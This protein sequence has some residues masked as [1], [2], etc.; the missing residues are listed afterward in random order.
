MIAVRSTPA[1]HFASLARMAPRTAD[2]AFEATRLATGW[3]SQLDAAEHGVTFLRELL[4]QRVSVATPRLVF[5]GFFASDDA[6]E[7]H[8]RLLERKARLYADVITTVENIE[9]ALAT[10]KA[11]AERMGRASV[12]VMRDL[13]V[14][15][16][17]GDASACRTVVADLVA[18][19][20]RHTER[21]K[22]LRHT[23]EAMLPTDVASAIVARSGARRVVLG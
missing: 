5:G 10:A 23:L 11:L 9:Q 15:Q 8:D 6:V 14:L 18:S 21:T 20:T 16:Q 17:T 13:R 19:Y 2:A 12:R 7:P 3:S 1:A 22:H 4:A